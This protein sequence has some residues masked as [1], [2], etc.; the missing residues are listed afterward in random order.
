MDAETIRTT[1]PRLLEH[2]RDGGFPV[3]DRLPNEPRVGE[4]FVLSATRA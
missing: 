4:A 1:L 2:L 3:A